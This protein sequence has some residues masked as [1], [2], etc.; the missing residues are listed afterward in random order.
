MLEMSPSLSL[1]P[2]D[3]I[4]VLCAKVSSLVSGSIGQA[5]CV[6]LVLLSGFCYP[7]DGNDFMGLGLPTTSF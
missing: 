2:G 7:L 5:G 1:L 6:G 4:I 3:D